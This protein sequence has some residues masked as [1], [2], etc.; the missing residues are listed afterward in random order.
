MTT[1]YVT[2]PARWLPVWHVSVHRTGQQL[3]RVSR[4]LSYGRAVA[5][6]ELRAGRPR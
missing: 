1:W 6:A 5:A 4:H 3:R 2:R